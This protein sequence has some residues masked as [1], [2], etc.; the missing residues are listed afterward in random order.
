[1]TLFKRDKKFKK[2]KTS[3]MTRFF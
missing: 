3:P 1:L 2:R